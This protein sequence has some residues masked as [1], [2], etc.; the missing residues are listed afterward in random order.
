MATR[1][2]TRLGAASERLQAAALSTAVFAVRR[3]GPVRASNWG[4]A[5][6]RA[7]G[8]YLAVS[9]VADGN[10]RQA[11]P[12]LSAGERAVVIANVWENLGRTTAELPHLARYRR[13]T[14]GIG[15][16]IEGEAHLACLR[17]PGAQALFFSGHIGNW[18]L[19]LPIAASLGV[20][21][22]GA[23]RAAGN[24]RVNAVI[25]AMRQR[26]LGSGVSMFA[27]G[28]PIRK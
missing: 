5:L 8:P 23:Y 28:A 2:A 3:L 16:E 13:S 7:V 20:P 26:A 11:L 10:L 9:R 22:A 4:G 24:A 15:W 19:I 6:A 14:A 17:Q 18:E 1:T 27:K 21:V 12:L 25:Q